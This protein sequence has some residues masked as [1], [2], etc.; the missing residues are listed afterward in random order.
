MLFRSAAKLMADAVKKYKDVYFIQ[1]NATDKLHSTS[2]DGI[3]PSD[4]G[5]TIWAES[6]RKPIVKIL[7]KYGIQ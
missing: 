1:T 6:I 7:K 3:H 5:Y 2:V 4:H